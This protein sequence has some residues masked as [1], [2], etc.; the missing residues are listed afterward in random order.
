MIF[1][2]ES[3]ILGDLTKH[4]D[5]SINNTFK[6]RAIPKRPTILKRTDAGCERSTLLLTVTAFIDAINSVA[7]PAFSNKNTI[8]SLTV[9]S[10][11]AGSPLSS[12]LVGGALG[13]QTI[14][15]RL[16]S[17]ANNQVS[18]ESAKRKYKP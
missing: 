2:S 3:L 1:K 10:P 6:I 13:L 14:K 18:E 7:A 9:N 17:K 15:P 5:A 4:L 8:L 12:T 16:C 11:E